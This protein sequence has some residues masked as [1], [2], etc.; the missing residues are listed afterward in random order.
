[1]S[2][3][4]VKC[5]LPYVGKRLENSLFVAHAPKI[6]SDSVGVTKVVTKRFKKKLIYF[7]HSCYF[8]LL[9]NLVNVVGLKSNDLIAIG[10]S[11]IGWP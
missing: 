2:H 5:G 3:L 11:S 4:V 1:M 7:D 10:L 8:N 9:L 6:S